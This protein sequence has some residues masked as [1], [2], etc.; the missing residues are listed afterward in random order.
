MA[1]APPSMAIQLCSSDTGFADSLATGVSAASTALSPIADIVREGL[2]RD[3]KQLPPWLFYDEAGSLLFE[4]ITCLPEYYLTR[5][6][7]E[8]FRVHAGEMIAAAADGHRL[9]L[10]EL[11]AGSAD[12]TRTLLAAALAHQSAVEY[13][14]VDVSET[15]LEMACRRIEE[16]LPGV[17]TTP[18]VED[19][20][21]SWS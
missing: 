11:G 16:E 5:L 20:T 21:I 15:A 1:A 18:V 14:P 4:Q 2:A 3:P 19:Y 8:I 17:A 10:V 9:R 7:R 13:L 6:E 12:K